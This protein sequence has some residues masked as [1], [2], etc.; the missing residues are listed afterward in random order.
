[1][2]V[3][4]NKRLTKGKKGQKKKTTDVFL[5]K[6]WYDVR[7]PSLFKVRNACKTL[8]SRTKGT[9]IASEGLK[10]RTFE[11]NLADLNADE[12]Q[13]FRKVKLFAEDVQ[14]TNVLTTFNGIDFTRDK[15]CSLIKKWQ[16]LIEA[17]VEVK[18][19]D[20][21]TLRLFAI[22]FTKK[23]PNQLKKTAYA[24]S[25]QV[26]AIRKKMVDIMTE[27]TVKGDLNELVRKLIPGVI[28][29]E[30]EKACEAIYPL[31]NVYV[32]KVKVLK[33]PKFDLGKLMEQHG[34]TAEEIGAGVARSEEL[35]ETL[36]GSGGRL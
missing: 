33:R 11:V 23:R 31:Q 25:A 22:A 35:V 36:E 13:A 17:N 4:K 18:T 3:G 34:D 28:G 24:Q 32:R 16:T 8:V 12:D 29:K 9:K 5:T 30:M 15:L 14:G 6:E 7:A 21:Y 10:G 2:A 1:M 27:N 26:R 20:G 19:T